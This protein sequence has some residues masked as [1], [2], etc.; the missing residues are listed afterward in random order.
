MVMSDEQPSRSPTSAE[1]PHNN[2]TVRLKKGI[3]N[4][5]ACDACR[6]RKVRVS[7][8]SGCL[9]RGSV[10][11]MLT[12]AF[13][14]SA[15]IRRMTR[16]ATDARFSPSLALTTGLGGDE[17]LQTGILPGPA[18]LYSQT[19]K[20]LNPLTIEDR[21]SRRN[22]SAEVA[23]TTPAAAVV[24]RSLETI[25]SLTSSASLF[26]DPSPSGAR[27]ETGL[28]SENSCGSGHSDFPHPFAPQEAVSLAIEDWF[29]K[30]HPVAPILARRRFLRRYKEGE[31]ARNPIFCG[32]VVSICAATAATLPREHYGPITVTSSVDFIERNQLLAGGFF[33]GPSSTLDWCISM[34]NL[35]TALGSVSGADMS[36]KRSYHKLSEATMG[37]RYLAYYCM[38]QLDYVEQQL[39]RRLFS[40]LY[41]G[42]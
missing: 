41:V 10:K 4:K 31:A 17:G 16:D 27:Q 13:C 15:S 30:I 11:G 42:L 18:L 37:T 35:G 24:S 28:S 19:I 36:D 20:P 39:T 34:Y 14:N 7:E 25:V 21:H 12:S 6:S 32:L 26:L 8:T 3:R 29:E 23:N 22:C 9:L 5:N 1:T 40:L 2:N 33:Q 38:P